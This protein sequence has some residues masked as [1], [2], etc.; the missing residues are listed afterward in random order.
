MFLSAVF[1]LM[2]LVVVVCFALFIRR[3]HRKELGGSQEQ[4]HSVRK[5]MAR[6]ED[7]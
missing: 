6:R 2:V 3:W 4:W 7:D 5:I 1:G